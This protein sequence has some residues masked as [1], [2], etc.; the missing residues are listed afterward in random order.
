M[1]TQTLTHRVGTAPGT[2][3]LYV[4]YASA[5]E[6]RDGGLGVIR[7]DWWLTGRTGRIQGPVP[8]GF[9]THL[10][11]AFGAFTLRDETKTGIIIAGAGIVATVLSAV[12]GTGWKKGLLVGVATAVGTFGAGAIA[13]QTLPGR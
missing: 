2:S 11:G 12:L 10:N 5:A 4:P 9:P 8:R 7:D 3:T 6:M 1:L 13:N